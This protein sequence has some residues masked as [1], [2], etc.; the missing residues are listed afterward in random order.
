MDH[1]NMF[2]LQ[3]VWVNPRPEAPTWTLCVLRVDSRPTLLSGISHKGRR[4]SVQVKTL[5]RTFFRDSL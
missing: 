5:T 2:P 4:S 3:P 1:P